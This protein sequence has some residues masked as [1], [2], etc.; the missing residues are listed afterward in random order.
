MIYININ[1]EKSAINLG[2]PQLV[3]SE[4]MLG[5][6]VPEVVVLSCFCG[7]ISENFGVK[8]QGVTFKFRLNGISF[9]FGNE[10][11]VE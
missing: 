5:P 3:V 9:R 10:S 6:S 1:K 2:T 7:V 11:D 4:Q 8:F